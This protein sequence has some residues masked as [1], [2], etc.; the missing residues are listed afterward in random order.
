MIIE[1]D[2]EFGAYLERLYYIEN[3]RI[4][5]LSSQFN[6]PKHVLRKYLNL[7]KSN[8]S[9]TKLSDLNTEF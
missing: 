5:E 7:N 8:F 9:K 3:W 1:I 2:D 6:L 4:K